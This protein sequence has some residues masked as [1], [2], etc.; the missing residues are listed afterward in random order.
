MLFAACFLLFALFY[1][2][3]RRQEA[4]SKQQEAIL[5]QTQLAD[6]ASLI[7]IFILTPDL[8]RL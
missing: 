5:S 2:D 7:Y 6:D 8:H 1:H 4:N 3:R